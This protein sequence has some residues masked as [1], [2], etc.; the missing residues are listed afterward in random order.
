MHV[1]IANGLPWMGGAERWAVHVARELAQRGHAIAVAHHPASELG[2]LAAE[3]GA[4]A[5]PWIPGPTGGVGGLARAIA[6]GRFDVAVSTVRREHRAVG[7]AARLAGLP[8]SVAR[9]MSG[10]APDDGAT[11]C[12]R[13]RRGWT[14]RRVVLLAAANSEAGRR[15]AVRQGLLPAAR[16]VAIRNGVDHARFDPDRVSRGRFRA[17]L[18][19]PRHDFLVVS[20]SRFVERKGQAWE[21]AAL[22][23]LVASR[24][25]IHVAFVGP[26]RDEER[27]WRAGLVRRAAGFPGAARIRFLEE[28][29][30]VPE[31]LADA[32][33][34]V[35]ASVE[36]GLPNVVLEAMAMRVPVV[37][38]AI[39][40]TP[41]AVVDG[42]TGRLVPPRDP[43]ELRRAVEDLALTPAS[44]RTALG[45]GGRERVERLFG[46]RRMID[47][48]ERLFDRA[49]SATRRGR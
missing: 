21:L 24:P 38:T 34:L 27:V 43:A 40:G 48:Y 29:S 10:W 5:F 49:A 3:A 14:H 41:E 8:G 6:R 13:A 45:Q 18:G 37:A 23:P 16:V 47:A 28:R 15:E 33:L 39:C 20:I 30:D 7:L 17:E 32:D 22:G 46:M 9:L 26:C 36:E 1:L 2:V 44:R 4:A 11:A 12:P 35:R 25:D 42:S 19:I 31:I